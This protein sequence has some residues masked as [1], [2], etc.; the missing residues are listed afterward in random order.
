VVFE[1]HQGKLGGSVWKKRYII[2]GW[3]ITIC[4][5]ASNATAVTVNPGTYY[6]QGNGNAIYGFSTTMQFNIIT[7]TADNVTF[8][9]TIFN[10]T[11]INGIEVNI[12]INE[13]VNNQTYNFTHN[14]TGSRVWFNISGLTPN[15]Q[16][17][18]FHNGTIN[19]TVTS[20][21][22][23]DISFN[24]TNWNGTILIQ[25]SQAQ[26]LRVTARRNVVDTINIAD[27]IITILGIVL[28]IGAIMM[29]VF[30][31]SKYQ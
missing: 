4:I 27:N 29:I 18:I 31:V 16:Y 28:I 22:N 9:T 8:N 12:T 17:S 11:S 26:L 30:I 6:M 23:G 2:I 19:R 24:S 15:L 25:P 7:I 5:I 10:S 14:N 1:T 13:F 20:D 21:G 3:L